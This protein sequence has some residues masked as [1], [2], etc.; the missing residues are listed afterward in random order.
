MSAVK[1]ARGLALLS[2]QRF[3]EAAPLLAE[4]VEGL[5]LSVG[6]SHDA[7][8]TAHIE[9]ALALA[10]LGRERDAEVAIQALM[11]AVA[12]PHPLRFKVLQ[13]L[14]VVKRLLGDAQSAV[15]AQQESLAVIP[16]TPLAARHRMKGLAE[17]GLAQLDL[18]QYTQAAATLDEAL[19][20]FEQQQTRM[21]PERADALVGMGRVRLAR[22][23]AE[24]ARP[25]LERA[26][27]FWRNFSP[28][29][30]RAREAA[31]WLNAARA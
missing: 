23:G 24:A 3:A 18:Q 31:R 9:H 11:P 19:A 30:R 4:A 6:E 26:D 27:A 16:G 28:G 7:T 5:R 8:L 1:R 25:F 21:T 12:A 10:N 22:D 29:S 17:L 2:A 20:L 14:G 13:A 15:L